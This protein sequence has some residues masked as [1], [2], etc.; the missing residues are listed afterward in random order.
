MGRTRSRRPSRRSARPFCWRRSTSHP[1]RAASHSSSRIRPT[2]RSLSSSGSRGSS[3]ATSSSGTGSLRRAHSAYRPRPAGPIATPSRS[4]PMRIRTLGAGAGESDSELRARSSR[5]RFVGV[6]R[7]RAE[8]DRG[9]QG[10][11]VDLPAHGRA[12]RRLAPRGLEFGGWGRSRGWRRAA[13]GAVRARTS[14]RAR[15]RRLPRSSGPRSRP[16]QATRGRSRTRPPCRLSP[17][18]RAPLAPGPGA[19]R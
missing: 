15:G 19:F 17:A 3:R 11:L 5:A 13:P 14:S 4:R 10:A 9:G 12:R 1:S 8:P 7:R 18:D 6:V 16:R 2:S